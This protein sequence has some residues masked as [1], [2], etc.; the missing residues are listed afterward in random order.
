MVTPWAWLDAVRDRGRLTLS[1]AWVSVVLVTMKTINRTRKM[2]VR[3]VTLISAT[4]SS[5]PAS[6]DS[7]NIAIERPLV[8]LVLHQLLDAEPEKGAERVD[9]GD[10]PVV[11]GQRD[12]GHDQPGCRRHQPLGNPGRHHRKPPLAGEGHVVEGAHDA[13]DRPEQP[14]ERRQ[15][16]DRGQDPQVP[17][18][19]VQ[20][21]L[22]LSV[23]L[24]E[25]VVA[26]GPPEQR[27]SKDLGHR[28]L[29][30][31]QDDARLGEIPATDP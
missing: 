15:R 10:E 3:G 6:S 31:L 29:G 30:R 26:V 18:Q 1:P 17:A 5:W 21:L 28:R 7:G 13:E 22:A 20:E 14:D 12:D 9:D 25:P 19:P 23:H 16:P 8:T 27:S 11:G 24:E 4:T 2:S